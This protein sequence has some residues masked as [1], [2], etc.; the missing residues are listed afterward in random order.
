MDETRLRWV[1]YNRGEPSRR[2]RP[3]AETERTR[4]REQWETTRRG[5][6]APAGGLVRAALEARTRLSTMQRRLLGMLEEQAGSELLE[7]VMALEVRQGILRFE[8]A[9]P[10]IL[11][12]LRMRWEQRLLGLVDAYLP[13]LGIHGVRFVL[14]KRQHDSRPGR[15]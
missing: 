9:E 12:D 11:Y 5:Q 13:E 3:P 10:A 7:H 1:H 8:T 15:R 4:A 2:P 6:A 14:A